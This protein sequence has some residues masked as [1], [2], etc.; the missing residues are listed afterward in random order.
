MSANRALPASGG[1][2]P[3]WITP[4][5][6]PFETLLHCRIRLSLR[7]FANNGVAAL[8]Q[9]FLLQLEVT[10]HHNLHLDVVKRK[11]S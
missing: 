9:I 7:H 6:D 11:Q 10:L 1:K 8:L 4:G 3:E 2:V 5:F